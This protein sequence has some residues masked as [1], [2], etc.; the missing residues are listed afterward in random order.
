MVRNDATG[1]YS[2]LE[3]GY[4]SKHRHNVIDHVEAK[5]VRIQYRCDQCSYVCNGRNPLRV[6]KYRR[7]RKEEGGGAPDYALATEYV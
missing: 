6:H 1:V 5:H 4:Q 2:C 7:H 3:C